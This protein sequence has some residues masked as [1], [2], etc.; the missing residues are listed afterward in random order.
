[1]SGQPRPQEARYDAIA[2]WYPPWVGSSAGLVC[3]P[4]YGL[5]PSHLQGQRW[6]DVACGSGRTARELARRGA[7]VVGV[8]VSQ[9]LI[10]RAR[11]E[12]GEQHSPI[13][14]QVADVTDPDSWWDGEPF[15]G[16]VCEMAVMDIDDLAGTVRAVARVVRPAGDFLVSM[17]NPCF[18]G[19]GSGLSSWPPDR[20]Y[21]AE[22]FWTSPEHNPEGVRAR[23]GSSHR[24]L[25]TYLNTFLD[26][27]FVLQRVRE[28]RTAVPTWLVLALVRRAAPA[29]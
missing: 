11:A 8:D 26:E 1:M 2:D 20:G 6:L 7:R 24:T 5:L 19:A 21:A 13:C 3:D 25:A 27:G 15:D 18:P 10:A 17:V 28:P 22:G 23:V 4:D 16:A 29:G 9:K 12:Q 14:Y